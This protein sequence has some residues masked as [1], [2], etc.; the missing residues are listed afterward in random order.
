MQEK[1]KCSF[2]RQVTD[3]TIISVRFVEAKYVHIGPPCSCTFFS[4]VNLSEV[5]LRL[6]TCIWTGGQSIYLASMNLTEVNLTTITIYN[7]KVCLYAHEQV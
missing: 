7:Y 2:Q 1:K 4:Q 5:S 6:N 3:L